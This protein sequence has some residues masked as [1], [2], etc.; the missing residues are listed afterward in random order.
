MYTQPSS[1]HHNA[2]RTPK[3]L[4]WQHIRGIIWGWI[5]VETW[6]CHLEDLHKADQLSISL[7]HTHTPYSTPYPLIPLCPSAA[8]CIEICAFYHSV[9]RHYTLLNMRGPWTAEN[10][11]LKMPDVCI[12]PLRLHLLQGKTWLC[13]L[14]CP[15]HAG[16]YIFARKS[17][18]D[19]SLVIPPSPHAHKTSIPLNIPQTPVLPQQTPEQRRRYV[20][21]CRVLISSH[22][23]ELQK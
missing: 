16:F 12:M 3:S 17:T 15:R 13:H 20:N 11:P 19:R 23:G 14:P 6:C 10:E 9:T 5:A 2:G 1:F 18:S 8:I 22:S 21:C 4:R 7:T